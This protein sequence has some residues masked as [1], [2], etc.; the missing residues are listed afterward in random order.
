MAVRLYFDMD[1]AETICYIPH[2]GSGIIKGPFLPGI[3]KTDEYGPGETGDIML[4]TA[5]HT[6][7]DVYDIT[8]KL[9]IKEV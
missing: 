2:D 9:R 3:A 1:P 7:N 8:L 4:T 6:A 5:G